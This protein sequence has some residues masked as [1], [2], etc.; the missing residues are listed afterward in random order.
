MR[1]ATGPNSEYELRKN[2]E[3]NMFM[4]EENDKTYE[5]SKTEN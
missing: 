1:C 5:E 4:C 3:I 2:Q